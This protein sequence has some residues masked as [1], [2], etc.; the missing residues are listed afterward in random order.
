MVSPSARDALT[1]ARILK[2]NHAGEHGTIRIYRSQ[3]GVAR[4]RC[5]EAVPALEE[6]LGH[7]IS[8][9]DRFAAAMPSRGARPCR[10]LFLWAVGGRLLVAIGYALIWISTSGD[11][12]RMAADLHQERATT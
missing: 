9:R 7:E 1:I 10:A 3:I 5:P 8:H 2:V 6:M 11:S 4:W 12:A